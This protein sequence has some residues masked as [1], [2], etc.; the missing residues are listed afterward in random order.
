MLCCNLQFVFFLS[1][2][3]TGFVAFYLYHPLPEGIEEP[4]KLRALLGLTKFSQHM[5]LI[6]EKLDIDSRVNI[7]RANHQRL[8]QFLD[9]WFPCD[10]EIQ[11]ETQ[12]FS[13]I[14]VR[15]F[16]PPTEKE[17]RPGVVYVHGG[18]FVYSSAGAYDCFAK[19]LAKGLDAVVVSVDYSLA[20]EAKF[21]KPFQ[22]SE[23]AT[24]H[25]LKNLKLFG[26]DPTKVLLIGDEVGANHVAAISQKLRTFTHLPQPR[27]QV[28]ITPFLQLM[29][30]N[31]PSYAQ[32][33]NVSKTFSRTRFNVE[34]ALMYMNFDPNVAHLVMDNAH[35]S[36]ELKEAY[37]FLVDHHQIPVKY[38]EHFTPMPR[39][40]GNPHLSDQFSNFVLHP[41]CFPLM[42]KHLQGLPKA[43]VIVAEHDTL[44]DDGMIYAHRM[45]QGGSK[46]LLKHYKTGFHGMMY[47]KGTFNV[48]QLAFDEMIEFVKKDLN[49]M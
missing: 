31:L 8:V 34:S 42:Q 23:N 41:Y 7:S 36:P 44:R 1:S 38:R 37:S 5:A 17:N 18:T 26:V 11:V 19:S 45:R 12:K 48:G 14:P 4:W 6:G 28:L 35:T 2:I 39:D 33:E 9:K 29:D 13:D 46:A 24:R 49:L 3:L 47:H 20:P 25:F 22:E 16:T 40:F 21:P 27:L 10:E 30:L 43:Y 32:H 15:L